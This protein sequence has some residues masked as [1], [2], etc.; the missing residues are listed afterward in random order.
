MPLDSNL[1]EHQNQSLFLVVIS[2][3]LL[4]NIKNIYAKLISNAQ[5]S[6]P[7]ISYA[8]QRNHL[9]FALEIYKRIK[10]T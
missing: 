8:F 2:Q 7:V 6:T 10:Y 3:V 5:I 9:I 1:L 4:L